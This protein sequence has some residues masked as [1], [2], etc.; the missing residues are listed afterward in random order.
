METN[1]LKFLKKRYSCKEFDTNKKVS[2]ED[3]SEII[4]IFRLSPSMLNIQP[5]K[6]FIIENENLKQELQ[7]YAWNQKQVWENSH[8]IVFARKNEIDKNYISLLSENA[9]NKEKFSENI[10]NFIEKM[11]KE[12]QEIWWI[13]QVSIAFWNVLNFLALKNIDSCAI[14]VFDRKKF[15]EILKLNEKWFSSVFNLAI[16]YAKQKQLLVI[17]NRLKT[18][19][20]VEYL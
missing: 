18:E 3:L 5:W 12:E 17:K 14:W 19:N 4:E 13:S 16:W 15:D 20:I 9:K 1:F 2:K 7:K 6:I 11:T 8:F 10:K